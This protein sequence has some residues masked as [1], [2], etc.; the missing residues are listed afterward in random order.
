MTQWRSLTLILFCGGWKLAHIDGHILALEAF[1]YV[2]I[3]VRFQDCLIL[4]MKFHHIWLSISNKSYRLGVTLAF[5]HI[6]VIIDNP[7]EFWH[8][9]YRFLLFQHTDIIMECLW[10]KLM[11]GLSVILLQ[12]ILIHQNCSYKLL[13]ISLAFNVYHKFP[14][15][16]SFFDILFYSLQ[17]WLVCL[18]LLVTAVSFIILP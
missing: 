7:A 12:S 14:I 10:Q 6:L 17:S 15:K 18:F 2:K 16:L 4:S 5:H 9:M 13:S 3:N 1:K 11:T 8:S